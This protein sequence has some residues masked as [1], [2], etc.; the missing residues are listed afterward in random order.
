MATVS[1]SGAVADRLRRWGESAVRAGLGDVFVAAL[2][3][4]KQDLEADPEAWGDPIRDF[5][6]VQLTHYRR[7]GPVLVVHY[8]VHIDGTPVFVLDVELTQGSVLR[9]HL[10]L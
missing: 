7:Y 1:Y 6:A 5:P 9:R 4:M 8:A 2:R 3:E 10:G